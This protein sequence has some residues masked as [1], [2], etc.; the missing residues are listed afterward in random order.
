[1]RR[2][3]AA[4]EFQFPPTISMHREYAVTENLNVN[5]QF[6]DPRIS[7]FHFPVSIFH[8]FSASGGNHAQGCARHSRFHAA[9]A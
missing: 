8:S 3:D 4:C 1:M 6:P 2:S 7:S 9:E 5:F